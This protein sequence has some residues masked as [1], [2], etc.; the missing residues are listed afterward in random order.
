M[1][2]RSPTPVD[3]A[4][5]APLPPNRGPRTAWGPC[6]TGTGSGS[7]SKRNCGSWS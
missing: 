7:G 5:P 6:G 4:M 2:R 1:T 3:L